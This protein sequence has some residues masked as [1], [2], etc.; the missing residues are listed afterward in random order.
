MHVQLQVVLDLD[1]TLVMSYRASLVPHH[2]RPH[3]DSA[4]HLHCSLGNASTTGV[5]AF[6]RPGLH[7]FLLKASQFAELIVFTAALSGEGQLLHICIPHGVLATA[8]VF[9]AGLGVQIETVVR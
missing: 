9:A 4:L 6:L 5:V 7:E 3:Q 2:L 8:V 1:E